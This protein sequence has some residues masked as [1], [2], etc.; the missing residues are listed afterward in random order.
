MSIGFG[1]WLAI[2]TSFVVLVEAVV[3]LTWLW[4]EDRKSETWRGLMLSGRATQSI[5]LMSVLIRWAIGTLAA[6]TTSMAASIALELHGV[7]MSAIAEVSI[8]RFTNSGPQSLKKMLPGTT[9]RPWLRIL[10][11]CLFALVGASQFASTLLVSDLQELSILSLKKNMT[12]GFNFGVVNDST[13]PDL[14]PLPIRRDDLQYWNRAPYQSETFAEYSEPGESSEELDDTGTVLRAFLPISTKAQ[15]ESI[16]SFNGIARVIDTRVI[17]VRPRF[18]AKYC[19]SRGLQGDWSLCLNATVDLSNFPPYQIYNNTRLT[20]VPGGHGNQISS[21][22]ICRIPRQRP[23]NNI[24]TRW[25]LCKCEDSFEKRRMVALHS[26]L[27]KFT[28]R[29]ALTHAKGYH[30]KLLADLSF[31]EDRELSFE[32]ETINTTWTLLNSSNSGPWAQQWNRVKLRD[33]VKTRDEYIQITLCLGPELASEVEHLKI[34]ANT[35]SSLTEPDYHF[36]ISSNEYD[37]SDILRQLGAAGTQ[38][39]VEAS[40]R[41]ILNIS[42]SMLNQ[43]LHKRLRRTTTERT[44]EDERGSWLSTLEFPN[45]AICSSCDSAGSENSEMVT[46]SPLTWQ[47]FSDIISTTNS[48]ALAIQALTTLVWRMAYYDHITSYSEAGQPAKVTTF[49]LV[50]A[51]GPKWGFVALMAIVAG[52]IMIFLVMAFIFLSHTESS[53]LENAW[54]TVAQISQSDNVRP[55]LESATLASDQD[56]GRM[57]RV[58]EP[59]KDSMGNVKDFFCGIGR[60]FTQRGTKEERLVVRD[61]LLIGMRSE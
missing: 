12:Y 56:V 27:T 15:R 60:M 32:S 49:D 18:T 24:S 3:F 26:P 46:V 43:S 14:R 7:P 41:Q 8:A 30:F 6:I 40:R 57:I 53:F 22:F 11:I 29:W 39:G 36:N 25:L 48:P 28:E 31:I 2:A 51:P 21:Y 42:P 17:C 34:T 37:T 44:A 50:Q 1:V 16:Q 9:F 61:G 4:F 20:I 54:H 55:V 10:M 47:I 5:T 23:F 58:E 33:G 19:R 38:D 35:S 52:N 13:A 45:L 59:P